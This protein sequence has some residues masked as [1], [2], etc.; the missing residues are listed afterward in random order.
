MAGSEIAVTFSQYWKACTNVMPFIPPKKTLA[1]MRAP[2]A[3]TPIQYGVPR[4]ARRVTPAPFSCGR[5]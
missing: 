4:I 5:R 3:T 2:T 1:V